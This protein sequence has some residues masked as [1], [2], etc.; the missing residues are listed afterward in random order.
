MKRKA[1]LPSIFLLILSIITASAY[2]EVATINKNIT[3][4]AIKSKPP[5]SY[6]LY[7]ANPHW[8]YRPNVRIY[9][10]VCCQHQLPHKK[11]MP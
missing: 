11:H 1:L 4:N 7:Y 10:P 8:Q 9:H 6:R 5:S 3:I 2:S